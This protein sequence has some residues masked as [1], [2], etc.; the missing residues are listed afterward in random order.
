MDQQSV[1]LCSAQFE[2]SVLTRRLFAQHE[3]IDAERT[4]GLTCTVGCFDWPGL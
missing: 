3:V 1:L 2:F 4:R